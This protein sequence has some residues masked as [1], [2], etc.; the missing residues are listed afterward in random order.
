M[1]KKLIN[2]TEVGENISVG[3]AL[4]ENDIEFVLSTY[5]VS[6]SY[7]FSQQEWEEFV[8]CVN[9]ANMSYRIATNE[10]LTDS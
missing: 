9:M 8:K 3:C 5:E 6:T 7:I 4:T 1:M 2:E 10:N